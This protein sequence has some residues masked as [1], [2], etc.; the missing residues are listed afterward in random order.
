MVNV[1]GV[2]DVVLTRELTHITVQVLWANL[3]IDAL[4]RPLEGGPERLDS[5]GVGH[6]LDVL[7]RAMAY[8]LV[9]E[10]QSFVGTVIVVPPINS[11]QQRNPSLSG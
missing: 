9:L 6:L 10:W 3:V 1:N 7:A 2:A 8:T 4:V 5:V 11:V